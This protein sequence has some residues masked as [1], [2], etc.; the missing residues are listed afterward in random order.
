MK[1]NLMS[2]S[3]YI[4]LVRA[5]VKPEF[6]KQVLEAASNTLKLTL[7]EPGCVAFYQTAL[8]EDPLQLCFFEHF[9]SE[10][11]HI[12]HLEKSYTKSFLDFLADKLEDAPVIQRLIVANPG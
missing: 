5:A 8:A 9:A 11:S 3:P 10:S 2:D 6:I 1:G 4:L 7:A 12:E